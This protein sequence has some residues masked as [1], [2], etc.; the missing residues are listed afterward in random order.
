ML[1]KLAQTTK[2]ISDRNITSAAFSQISWV[3]SKGL[4]NTTQG[5]FGNKTEASQSKR[6][7]SLK[8][9]CCS[10]INTFIHCHIWC[11]FQYFISVIF[12]LNGYLFDAIK[13]AIGWIVCLT[14][15]LGFG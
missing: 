7:S 9:K 12:K 10:Q 13:K 3:S 5:N 8:P 2:E 6:S 4:G 15:L 11:F 1:V 14:L